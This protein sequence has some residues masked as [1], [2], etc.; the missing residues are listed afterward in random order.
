MYKLEQTDNE[1]S[2]W[3]LY[4]S[5]FIFLSS[6]KPYQFPTH[7]AGSSTSPMEVLQFLKRFVLVLLVLVLALFLVLVF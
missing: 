1:C 6:V 7:V 5:D 2:P 3:D 4:L